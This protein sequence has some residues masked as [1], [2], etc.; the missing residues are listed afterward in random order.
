MEVIRVLNNNAVLCTDGCGQTILLGR[1]LGFGKRLGDDIDPANAEQVFVPNAAQSIAN[2]TQLSV[3]IPLEMIQ[4]AAEIAQLVGRKDSQALVLG[5][6]DHISFAVERVARNVV[7]EYPLRWEIAQL[8][9]TEFAVGRKSLALIAERTGVQLPDDEAALLAMHFVNAQFNRLGAANT[10]PHTLTDVLRIVESGIGSALD[11]D[12]IDVARFITHLRYLFIRLE[13]GKLAEGPIAKLGAV[14]AQEAP[15]AYVV[16]QHVAEEL[17]PQ[18]GELSPNEI[19][20]LALHIER[21][22]RVMSNSSSM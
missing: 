12:S 1:G 6:A 3:D 13:Q 21:L 4:L 8:F 19:G 9:P 2:L 22:R 11:R 10:L 17:A 15:T 18:H 7:I 14:I 5:L 16:A 20:Y